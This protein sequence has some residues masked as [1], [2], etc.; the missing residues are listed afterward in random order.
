MICLLIQIPWTLTIP[1]FTRADL[2]DGLPLRREGMDCH[3]P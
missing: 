2:H 1:R 3:A